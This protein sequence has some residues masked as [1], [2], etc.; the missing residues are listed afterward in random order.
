MNTTV[1]KSD[2][3]GHK[4]LNPALKIILCLLGMLAMG[5]FIY[6][7]L[8]AGTFS[9]KLTIIRALVFSGFA[10]LLAQSVRDMMA[11]S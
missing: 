7:E 10:Y 4:F 2:M 5:Y 11:G 3:V 6:P 9:D 1:R 8:E